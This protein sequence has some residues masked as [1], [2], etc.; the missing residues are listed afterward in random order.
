M[1]YSDTHIALQAA[2]NAGFGFVTIELDSGEITM[3]TAEAIEMFDDLAPGEAFEIIHA[4]KL[5]GSGPYV[6]R[7][8]WWTFS[9]TPAGVIETEQSLQDAASPQDGRRDYYQLGRSL[10][11][12]LVIFDSK[13]DDDLTLC[14]RNIYET[15]RIA[16]DV[17][18]QPICT[19]CLRKFD[20]LSD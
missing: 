7:A 19:N 15:G 18:D 8:P 13:T 2:D 3:T 12:H 20:K 14:G 10:L 9:A 6:W 1:N 11:L 5:K 17:D 4:T 16:N